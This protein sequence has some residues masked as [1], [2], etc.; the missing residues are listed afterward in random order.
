[1]LEL[2]PPDHTRMRKL[3]SKAFT[4][5]A[6]ETLR[7]RIEQLVADIVAPAKQ[8]GGMDVIEV[9]AYPLPVIVIAEMLDVPHVLA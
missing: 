8:R 4:P 3:V 9:L 6:I 1:M 5:R 2:D 7:P